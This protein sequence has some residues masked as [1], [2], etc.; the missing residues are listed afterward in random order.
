MS[1]PLPISLS[2]K[3]RR[4]LTTITRSPSAQARNI[5]R[6]RIIL[7]TDNGLHNQAVAER[8][9]CN[10][11]TVRLW[12]NRF[13]ALRMEGLRDQPRR[14]RTITNETAQPLFCGSKSDPVGSRGAL[15]QTSPASRVPGIPAQD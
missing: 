9:G 10:I 13:L 6:A 7:A 3:E 11:A 15:F 14:G 1:R 2:D 5:L 12:R 8:V 4:S